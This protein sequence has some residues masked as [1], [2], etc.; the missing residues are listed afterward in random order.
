M[1]YLVRISIDPNGTI[2]LPCPLKIPHLL[3]V[4][5]KSSDLYM[6]VVC[7]C[8]TACVCGCVSGCVCQYVSVCVSVCV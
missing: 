1:V 7:G 6:S 2:Y 5:Y 4:S 3:Q 8:V